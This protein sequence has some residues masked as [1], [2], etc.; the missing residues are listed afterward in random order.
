MKSTMSLTPNTSQSFLLTELERELMAKAEKKKEGD[1][2]REKE[3]EGGNIGLG[4]KLL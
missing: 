2:G 3:E 1:I 4:H